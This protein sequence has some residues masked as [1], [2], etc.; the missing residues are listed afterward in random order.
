MDYFGQF[1]LDSEKDII[2]TLYKEG[3]T[4]RYVLRTPHHTTGNLITNLAHLCHLPITYEKNGYKMIE[5]Q[6]PCYIDGHNQQVYIFRLGNTKVANIY[7]DG[8]ID[9]KASIPAIAKTLM[10]QTKDYDLDEF[11]TLVKTYI[12]EEVK[13]HSDLH[14]HRNAN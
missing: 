13:F 8:Q 10:S 5:G 9:Q 14:T 1:Y 4:L 3:K 12:R 11:K 7:P 2:I 6:I